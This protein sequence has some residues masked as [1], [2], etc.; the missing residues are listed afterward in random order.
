MDSKTTLK[1][2]EALMRNAKKAA[3]ERGVTLTSVVE[4]A[5]RA[6]LAKPKRP[7]KR[8]QRFRWVVIDDRHA[9]SP[10]VAERRGLYDRMEPPR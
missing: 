5:L 1:L 3:A 7:A 2:D 4:D 10:D 9:S 6:H 8:D